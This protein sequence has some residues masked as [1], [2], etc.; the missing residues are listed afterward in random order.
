MATHHSTGNRLAGRVALVTGASRG[1]GAA[2]A[3]RLVEEGATV[4]AVAENGP[5]LAD[6]A[7]EAARARSTGHDG[8]AVAEPP[9]GE[10]A[11]NRMIPYQAD[12]ALPAA[13]EALAEWLAARYARL[14][15]LVHAAAVLR[16]QPLAE[17]TL[18]EFEAT[19]EI[20]FTS[21]VRL[22]KL[23]LPQIE[24]AGRQGGASIINVSSRAGVQGFALE[25]DY[26]A[27]KF[28]LEGFSYSLAQ[29]L[30]GS[31]V[32]VNLVTPGVRIKPTSVT[33][34]E[35]AAWPAE[36]RAPF[37]DPAV[38]TDAFVYLAGQGNGGVT[39]RRFDAFELSERVRREG[40]TLTWP[41]QEGD[42]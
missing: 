36:R 22:V 25:T 42:A 41:Q 23:L 33:R 18:A 39:G 3:L 31:Q 35:F 32:A 19:L 12:L 7:A 6:L 10:A 4:I 38:M 21:M 40:W 9:A 37:H 13:T 28:A 17:L 24:A 1:F 14:D 27:A 11:A 34:A 5:E 29:E 2:V 26:C 20:N 30:R 8:P 16:N 15:V